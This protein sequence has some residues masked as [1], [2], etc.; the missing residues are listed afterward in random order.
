MKATG[1][2][3]LP[4]HSHVCTRTHRGVLSHRFR[5]SWAPDTLRGI[6]KGLRA[7]GEKRP[8]VHGRRVEMPQ[9]QQGKAKTP[10]FPVLGSTPCSVAQGCG[11]NSRLYQQLSKPQVATESTR[12]GTKEPIHPQVCAWTW[13]ELTSP[14]GWPCQ[15]PARQAFLAHRQGEGRLLSPNNTLNLGQAVATSPRRALWNRAKGFAWGSPAATPSCPPGAGE[16]GREPVCFC[17]VQ[18]QT[19]G[20]WEEGRAQS[21]HRA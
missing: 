18:L 19:G 1:P 20:I 9:N 21:T 2:S 16:R 11:L 8:Q 17:L 10:T 15:R 5:E 3:L 7:Q 14:L 4:K 6:L 13:E 12:A